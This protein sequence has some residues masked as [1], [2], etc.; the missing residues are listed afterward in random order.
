MLKNA[1]NKT[2]IAFGDQKISYTEMFSQV[3]KFASLIRSDKSDHMVIFSENRPGWIFAFYAIWKVKGVAIPIDYLATA[4]EVAYILKDSGPTVIFCS[5]ASRRVMAEATQ[6]AGISAKMIIIDEAESIPTEP[7]A[8]SETIQTAPEDTAVIIYTSGTTGS[9]KGVMLSYNNILTNVRAVSEHIR[10]Y[11]HD[12]R[13]MILLPLH[14]IFPLV[15]TMIIPL[16]LGAMVA[17]SPSMV[18][19]DIMATLKNNSITIIIGVPRLYAAIRKGIMD[20]IKKSGVARLLFFIARKVNSPAFSKRIFGTVHRKLGGSVEFLVSGG[21]ALDSEV[22]HDLQTLG[23]EVLEGYG[24]TEAAPMITFTQPRRVRIGSPGEVMRETAVQI[25]DG[26]IIASGPNIMQGYYKRPEETAEVLKNG[27]LYTG[28]LGYIDK[29]GFLYI[30]GR[31]KEII[32]LS[33]GKNV[34]PSEIESA[35]LESPLVKDCGVFLKDNQ[36]QVIILP[37]IATTDAIK[38][39]NQE[40][41]FRHDLIEPFNNSV[42]AYKKLMRFYL[43]SEELPRTRLGK[44]QRFKLSDLA[45]DQDDEREVTEENEIPEFKIIAAYIREEKGRKVMPYHHLEMDLGMDSL[46]KV[47]FQA[48]LQQNFGVNIEPS[49]MTRFGDV[50]KLSE[51]VSLNKT[52]MEEGKLNWTDILREKVNLKLP[53][54][55]FTGRWMVYLSRA[56]FHLYF[57]FRARGIENIPEGPFILAPNHQSVFDGLFVAAYLRGHQIRKTYVYAKEKHIKQRWLKF[58]ANRNNIIIVD[59][60][61]DLKAS[62]QKMAEVLKQ[63]RNLII[64]PEGTRTLNGKLGQFK[65]TFAILSRELNIPIVPVSIDGAFKALPKGSHFPRPLTKIRIEFLQ[66]VYPGDHSYDTISHQVK[67]S[68]Q[69][70]LDR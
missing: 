17:I 63:D 11:R 47:G 34:N 49:E 20:K 43:T 54:T 18:S 13:V 33:N 65:K 44:L 52:H 68:I 30:T 57:R 9:P 67:D 4:S 61:R 1:G 56:F 48:W 2:A 40:D 28:D 66:P 26:E 55:W 64:F 5:E 31:K 16:Y 3:E 7:F 53:D 19:E 62:I 10:I 45:V 46:D 38:D 6:I 58:L 21:A 15:G 41:I 12:S 50:S 24:M 42:S 8:D 69:G 37:E 14:H 23:F 60:N 29:E 70:N 51:F 22:G 35:L 27:W 25:K 36:L 39:S 59:L 32:V